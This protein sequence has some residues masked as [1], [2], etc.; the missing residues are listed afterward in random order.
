MV[1]IIYVMSYEHKYKFIALGIFFYSRHL[2]SWG[3]FL[4]S[5]LN[6]SLRKKASSFTTIANL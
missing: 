1:A 6:I 3:Y 5:L 4:V 2:F